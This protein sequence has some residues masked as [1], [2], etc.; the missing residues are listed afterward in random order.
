M[1]HKYVDELFNRGE[2]R[3]LIDDNFG[4]YVVQ[5]AVSGEII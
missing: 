1:K 3:G 5:T 2:V 4:N